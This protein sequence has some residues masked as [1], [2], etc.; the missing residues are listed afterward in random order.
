MPILTEAL[1]PMGA[2]GTSSKVMRQSMINQADVCLMRVDFDRQYGG[3]YSDSRIIGTAYHAGVAAAYL[4]TADPDDPF[5]SL[6][7]AVRVAFENEV[8][9][10]AEAEVKV[11]WERCGSEAASLVKA[12]ELAR[13]YVHKHMPPL[14][15]F[16]ILA[17]EVPWWFPLGNGWIA[18]GT[19]DLVLRDKMDGTHWLIDHKTAG[20]PWKKGK[21]H[22]RATV[23]PSWYLSFWPTLWAMHTGSGDLPV[24]RFAFHIMTYDGKF[25][26]RVADVKTAHLQRAFDKATLVST[27]IDKGGPFWPNQSH[28]LCD[29]RWCDHWNRCGFGGL[30]DVERPLHINE[31]S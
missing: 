6:D 23:Q 15:L 21:E 11:E 12:T 18:H 14:D 1:D 26:Q 9:L 2:R 10:A 17:V 31:A 5:Y 28:F 27:I 8:K 25:E 13:L 29:E 4:H 19:I 30:L 3:G 20:R 22:A 24:A 16:E 7:G